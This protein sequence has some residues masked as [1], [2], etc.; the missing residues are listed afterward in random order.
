MRRQVKQLDVSIRTDRKE[1]KIIKRMGVDQKLI[2]YTKAVCENMNQQDY[3][4][5]FDKE[6][7]K[8]YMIPINS[9]HTITFLDHENASMRTVDLPNSI[10]EDG[11]KMPYPSR[12][13][14]EKL[15]IEMKNNLFKPLQSVIKPEHAKIFLNGLLFPIQRKPFNFDFANNKKMEVEPDAKEVM[16]FQRCHH[17]KLARVNLSDIRK[18]QIEDFKIEIFLRKAQ[19]ATF[20][21]MLALLDVQPEK[22]LSVLIV[23]AHLVAGNWVVKSELLYYFNDHMESESK[24]QHFKDLIEAREH[25]LWLLF[26]KNSLVFDEIYPLYNV[27]FCFLF[28]PNNF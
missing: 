5:R 28:L 14:H 2:G 24:K 13:R 22:L 6:A 26:T 18:I 16:D 20:D 25:L 1:L 4:V 17:W 9:K 10:V 21:E 27:S 8:M 12:N 15:V 19:V 7:R 3:A 23:I 11:F